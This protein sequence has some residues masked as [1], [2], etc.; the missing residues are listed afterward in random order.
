MRAWHAAL[1]ET[2]PGVRYRDVVVAHLGGAG[3]NGLV[4]AHGGDAVKL[5][6]LKRRAPDARLGQLLGSLA[7]PAALEALTTALLLAWAVATG[8]VSVPSPEAIPLP[9][10]GAA[11]ALAAGLLWVLA[12]KAPKLLR[13]VRAGMT[14]LRRPGRLVREVAP[15]VVVGRVFRLGAITCFLAAVGLPATL[16]GLLVVMA[17]QGG[18]GSNGPASAPVRIAVLSA[19]LPAVLG[20]HSVSIETATALIGAMQVCPMVANLAISLVVLAITLRT[21]SPRKVVGYCRSCI[22]AQPTPVPAMAEAPTTSPVST[23]VANP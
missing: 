22:A 19:S 5:G 7:P 18:V 2:A 23:F 9:I 4:P 14:T 13:D 10:V 16:A 11:A 17:I 12:R 6:L 21:T 15:W 8:V 1:A 3:F 20:V